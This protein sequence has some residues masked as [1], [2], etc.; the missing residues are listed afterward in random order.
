MNKFKD[1]TIVGIVTCNR[2]DYFDKLVKSIDRTCVKKIYVVIAGDDYKDYPEDVE[3]LRCK[4]NPTVVGAAKNILWRKM[5]ED[6]AEFLFT[7]EDD[8]VITDNAVW[9]AYIETAMDSGIWGSLA[10]GLHGGIA[11][12]NVNPDGT[13][14]KRATVKYTKYE[15]DFYWHSFAA[16]TFMHSNMLKHVGYMSEEYLNAAEHL[17]HYCRVAGLVGKKIVLGT[18]MYAFPDIKDSF[19][20]IVDQSTNHENSVIR[21]SPEFLKNFQTS[22]QIFKTKFGAFPTHMPKVTNESL[23]GILEE[24]EKA[25]ARKDLL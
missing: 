4:R 23:L 16:L 7:L 15:V 12:G 14:A 1:N 21:S 8:I 5:R 18:P 2:K 25:Y 24:L 13:P 9:Q 17:D 6:G 3:I 22:W 20:Y 10:Y 11:G 19:N